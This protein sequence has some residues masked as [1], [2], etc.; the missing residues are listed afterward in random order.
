MQK[1]FNQ[2]KNQIEKSAKKQPKHYQEELFSMEENHQRANS[3]PAPE[4]YI[5]SNSNSD[6]E[7]N[8]NGQYLKKVSYMVIGNEN[9]PINRQIIGDEYFEETIGNNK[10][11]TK[12]TSQT[13]LFINKQISADFLN[14]NVYGFTGRS[15]YAN[16]NINNMIINNLNS[17]TGKNI[18]TNSNKSHKNNSKVN[19]NHGNKSQKRNESAL[20]TQL[21]DK[22]LEYR[23]SI[24][25]FVTTESEELHKHL[26]LKKH[27][28]LPKKIKKNKK[29]KIFFKST[30]KLNQTFIYSMCRISKKNYFC[31]HCGKKFDSAWAL[32][33]HL[34][35]HRFR[36]DI[37][38]KLFNSKD[39]L[40]RHNHNTEFYYDNKR[41]NMFKKKEYKSPGKGAKT[42]I[43][44]W[45]EISSNKK[46][47]WESDEE[48]P[49]YEFEQT[50]TFIGD[51][52]DNFDF[53]QMVKIDANK[54][55]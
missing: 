11:K 14:E 10:N 23:C 37:C 12:E 18:K 16:P 30:N 53:N 4:I 8:R 36:C 2:E 40:I 50:Y 29:S 35:A 9:N 42:E 22:I 44:D 17:N 20:V 25:N 46:E 5:K 39:D 31:K 6:I 34:N 41:V 15:P 3:D 7:D 55:E 27:Y 47:K 26:S 28:T 33:A 1:N 38:H 24:C 52:E 48:I 43:D 32:N 21:K 45:E 19:S 49:K 13:N 51:T 54:N